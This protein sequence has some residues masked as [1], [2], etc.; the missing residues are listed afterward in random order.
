MQKYAI[1]FFSVLMQMCLG[2][3]YAWG[4]FANGFSAQFGVEKTLATA[5]FT[6]FYVAFP[7]TVFLGGKLIA[8]L[9]TRRSAMLGGA[10]FGLGWLIAGFGESHFLYTTIGAGLIGGFGVGLAYVSPISVGVSWWPQR[11]GLVT[12]LAVGG[13][14]GGAALVSEFAQSQISAGTSAFTVL[15]ICGAIYLITSLIAGSFMTLPES[16]KQQQTTTIK[17]PGLFK[18]L[19]NPTFLALFIAMTM[20]LTAGF[21]A[22]PNIKLF[23]KQFT[24]V[25][26]GAAILAIA[27]ALGRIIWGFISDQIS[28]TRTLRINLV[29]QAITMLLAYHLSQSALGL[30]I[31]A[32]ATGFN[33]GGVLVLYAATIGKIWG[34]AAIAPIYG[35]IFVTN[36]VGSLIAKQFTSLYNANFF[37]KGILLPSVVIGILLIIS[38]VITLKSL[39]V[40]PPDLEGQFN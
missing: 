13:F 32:A 40:N 2:G 38:A 22:I 17:V 19:R 18:I 26:S 9:G 7:L 28:I 36:I 21:F 1:L 8:K 12:G 25:I 11:R 31:L 37:E 35:K 15:Q 14:A 30:M 34:N 6:Y 23:E 10:L 4:I 29:L 27:N 5:P 24:L 20:G 3:T 33:Y 39:P 16:A